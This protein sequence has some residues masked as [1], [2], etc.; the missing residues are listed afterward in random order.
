MINQASALAKLRALKQGGD[1]PAATPAPAD[2]VVEP[3]ANDAPPKP[4][5]PGPEGA[6]NDALEQAVQK[7]NTGV[8]VQM[9][10]QASALAKLRALKQGDNTSGDDQLDGEPEPSNDTCE[11][12]EME[13]EQVLD[14]EQNYT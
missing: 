1:S 9:N 4:V 6:S 11:Q 13:T 10:N 8:K 14:L 2:A 7:A 3:A 12:A 5:Q